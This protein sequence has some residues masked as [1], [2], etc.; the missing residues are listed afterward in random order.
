MASLGNIVIDVVH[1]WETRSQETVTVVA[2]H[3]NSIDLYESTDTVRHIHG[4]DGP[5]VLDEFYRDGWELEEVFSEIP[6]ITSMFLVRPL[7][8]V[9]G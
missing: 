4:N 1:R 8:E 2:W 9:A 6:G 3:D 7:V 5:A